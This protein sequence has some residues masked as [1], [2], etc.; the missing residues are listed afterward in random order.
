MHE[1]VCVKNSTKQLLKAMLN[2][3]TTFTFFQ[4]LKGSPHGLSDA[5]A[6]VLSMLL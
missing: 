3:E 1:G 5:L 6:Y 4:P 2:F